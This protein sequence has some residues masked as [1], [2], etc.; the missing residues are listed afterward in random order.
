MFN[1]QLWNVLFYLDQTLRGQIRGHLQ[2]RKP[3][4]F[5]TFQ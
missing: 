4:V 2:N 1:I 3:K 5:R